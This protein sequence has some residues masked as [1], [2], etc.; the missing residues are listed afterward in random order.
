MFEKVKKGEKIHDWTWAASNLEP[1]DICSN[2]YRSLPGSQEVFSFSITQF[3]VFVSKGTLVSDLLSQSTPC[4]TN[5]IKALATARKKL[6]IQLRNYYT[7]CTF[8]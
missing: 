3:H 7:Y 1:S 2:T 5:W 8:L 4:G 6:E